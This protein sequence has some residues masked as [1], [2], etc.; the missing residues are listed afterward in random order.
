MPPKSNAHKKDSLDADSED[1][2]SNNSVSSKPTNNKQPRMRPGDISTSTTN[3]PSSASAT[4]VAVGARHPRTL[5]V[6]A[7]AVPRSEKKPRRAGFREQFLQKLRVMLDRESQN[8]D[9]TVQWSTDGNSFIIIDQA[10]FEEETIPT[11]F[12]N[13]IVFASFLRKLQRWGFNRVSSRRSGSYEFGSPTFKRMDARSTSASAD[14]AAATTSTNTAGNDGGGASSQV[15]QQQQ[16]QVM[17]QLNHQPMPNLQLP[18]QADTSATAD[19]IPNIHRGTQQPSTTTSSQQP[20]LHQNTNQMNN[21]DVNSMLQN[22][23]GGLLSGQNP[24]PNQQPVPTHAS[25]L[26]N[27]AGNNYLQSFQQWQHPN[28]TMNLLNAV[29][30]LVGVPT[31]STQMM[32][33]SDPSSQSNA[34]HALM[35]LSGML[36]QPSLPNTTTTTPA[37]GM[38]SS[39]GAMMS[40]PNNNNNNNMMSIIA[41]LL[42]LQRFA[43]DEYQRRVQVDA[44]QNAIIT[45][46][47]HILGQT[48]GFPNNNTAQQQ[49]QVGAPP[50][51]RQSQLGSNNNNAAQSSSQQAV[52]APP[53]SSAAGNNIQA[54]SIAAILQAAQRGDTAAA[55]PEDTTRAQ[56]NGPVTTN[57]SDSEDDDNDDDEDSEEEDGPP[58]ST[59]RKRK[60]ASPDED[61]YDADDDSWNERL[62]PRKKSPP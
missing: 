15:S 10:Q 57:N 24:V 12:G 8:D 31:S 53:P 43:E 55:P 42:V 18:R 51:S 25:Q 35:S 62:R 17:A 6:A 60:A 54:D 19:L 46:I 33:H 9:A 37:S 39:A 41:L 36:Q 61:Q 34:V 26:N 56:N 14:D 21:A 16:Q 52:G 1:S 40:Q 27:V 2:N 13:P 23:V 28:P 58:R 59:P 11:Y 38:S 44:I 29:L 22:I 48:G 7:A 45:T 32:G 20:V 30:N 3:E 47:G 5:H 50:P 4:D 49:Q